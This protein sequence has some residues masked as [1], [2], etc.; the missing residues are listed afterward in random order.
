MKLSLDDQIIDSQSLTL[1]ILASLIFGESIGFV[2]GAGF[3]LGVMG[4]LLPE[5]NI[6]FLSCK[7]KMLFTFIGGLVLGVR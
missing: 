5:V 6:D 1:A 2:G 3:V 7:C 4:L